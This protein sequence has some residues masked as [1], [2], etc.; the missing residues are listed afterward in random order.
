MIK[1]EI[2]C[3]SYED[4]LAA[5]KGNATRIELNS[6]LHLGGLT[7]A[8]GT[9]KLAKQDENAVNQ[10]EEIVKKQLPEYMCPI[11]KII[12]EI[13][14]NQNGKVDKKQLLEEYFK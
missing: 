11:I 12:E 6:A 13:P 2:C 14:L 8:I 9:V 4:C 10:L 5:Q 7:P 3:G 1:V